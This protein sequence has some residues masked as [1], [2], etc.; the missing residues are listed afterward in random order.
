LTTTA[1][2][3]FPTVLFAGDASVLVEIKA[4]AADYPL[5]RS[6]KTASDGGECRHSQCA[7]TTRRQPLSRRPRVGRRWAPDGG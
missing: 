2:I 3:A 7:R 6:L 1:V 4:V 5:A